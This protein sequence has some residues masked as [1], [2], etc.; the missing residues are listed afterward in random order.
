M[1]GLPDIYIGKPR[2]GFVFLLS[3]I[4]VSSAHRIIRQDDDD[5]DDV[6]HYIS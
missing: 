3:H 1:R 4:Y 2:T 5:A 6:S